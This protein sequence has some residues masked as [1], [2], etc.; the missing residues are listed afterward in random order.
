MG[1]LKRFMP[2]CIGKQVGLEEIRAL[3]TEKFRELASRKTSKEYESWFLKYN[4]ATSGKEKEEKKRKQKK[5]KKRKLSKRLGK[6][7]KLKNLF[8]TE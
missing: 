5:T 1:V 4:P 2:K 6:T 3:K 8:F 7:L